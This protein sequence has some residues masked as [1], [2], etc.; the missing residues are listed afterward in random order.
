MLRILLLVLAALL[1]QPAHAATIAWT[2]FN[3]SSKTVTA[4]K[5]GEC[6]RFTFDST[7]TA[8]DNSGWLAVR[9]Q[10]LDIEFE[11]DDTG[12]ATGATVD[13][14]SCQV[15]DGDG[16]GTNDTNACALYK[17]DTDGDG[18]VDNAE[19]D[20]TSDMKRA[21][22]DVQIPGYLYAVATVLPASG[23]EA[24]LQ[25]CSQAAEK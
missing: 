19:L 17:W 22:S 4:I 23:D 25:V 18:I 13:L 1:V 21:L 24:H 5:P 6:A 14:Y 20:G 3:D 8:D 9:G 2:D 15:A 7:D 16:D 10:I 11:P 12:S